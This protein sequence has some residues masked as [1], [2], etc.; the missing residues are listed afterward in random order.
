[1]KVSR[2]GHDMAPKVLERHSRF[3]GPKAWQAKEV[4]IEIIQ[5]ASR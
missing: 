5:L 3:A 2:A 1:V 4:M